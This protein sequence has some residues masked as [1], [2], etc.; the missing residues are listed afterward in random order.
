MV[1][2]DNKEISSLFMKKSFESVTS[3]LS[4]QVMAGLAA[5]C[6]AEFVRTCPGGL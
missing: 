3:R 2:A 5:K 6:I 4:H 1:A